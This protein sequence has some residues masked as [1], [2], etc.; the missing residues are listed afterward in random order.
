MPWLTLAWNF[1]YVIGAVLL[2][3]AGWAYLGH[4]D[5]VAEARGAAKVQDRWDE[6][7]VIDAAAV[8]ALDAKYRKLEAESKAAQDALGVQYAKDLK[9][10]KT[11]RDADV[12]AARSG[13]LRLSFPTPSANQCPAPEAGSGKPGNHEEARTELP[14]QVTADLLALADDA[15]EVVLQ[16]TACQAVVE[17][18]RQPRKES[19]P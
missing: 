14:R 17:A 11:R 1:R 3:G 8:T 19:D 15:D 7:K 5:N 4:R 9:A 6:Q 10:A 13:A 12:A 2:I 16:L 18:D